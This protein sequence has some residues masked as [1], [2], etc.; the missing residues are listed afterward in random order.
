MED[1]KATV[2]VA[3]SGEFEYNPQDRVTMQAISDILSFRYV[4]TIREEE[5]GTYGA[6]VRVQ[7]NKLP[8][9]NYV[10]TVQFDCDP[11]NAERLTQIVLREIQVLRTDG[12]KDDQVR[13]FKENKLKTW[14]ESLEENNFWMSN[15][16]N[17]DFNGDN[18]GDFMNY[19]GLVSAVTPEMVKEAAARYFNGDNLIIITLLPSDLSK[20]VKNPMLKK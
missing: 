6:G 12:P 11:E 18:L 19:P 7:T 4:E 5:G 2:F 9:G 16:A 13:N 15:L 1:P 10:L 3:L 17:A 8:K 14:K 20:S